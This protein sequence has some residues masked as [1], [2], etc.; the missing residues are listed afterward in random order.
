MVGQT[1]VEGL[2]V[3]HISQ[4]FNFNSRPITRSVRPAFTTWN[5]VSIS[6]A[7]KFSNAHCFHAIANRYVFKFFPRNVPHVETIK[8]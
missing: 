1:P 8:D 3:D 4:P 6:L 7:F 5:N 2:L